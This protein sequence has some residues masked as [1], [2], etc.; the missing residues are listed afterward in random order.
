LSSTLAFDDDCS[1]VCHTRNLPLL[2]KGVN[3]GPW[4]W[5]Q[6]VIR[7][8]IAVLSEVTQGEFEALSGDVKV[9]VECRNYAPVALTGQFSIFKISQKNSNNQRT[10]D[11][12]APF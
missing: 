8:T 6:T 11:R 7:P 10:V 2:K 1:K 3:E 9:D 5:P 12:G 4:K